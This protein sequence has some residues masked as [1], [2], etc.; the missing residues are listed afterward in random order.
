MVFASR[1]SNP[2]PKSLLRYTAQ[3]HIGNLWGSN[4]IC[5][6]C[7]E[8]L[9]WFRKGEEPGRIICPESIRSIL[10]F[11]P[12]SLS[13]RPK[14]C[15]ALVWKFCHLLPFRLSKQAGWSIA[16]LWSHLPSC[17][18][19]LPGKITAAAFF[20]TFPL[21]S[22][23]CSLHSR[24]TNQL[25]Q[26]ASHTHI[27]QGINQQLLDCFQ[28]PSRATASVLPSSLMCPFHYASWEFTAAMSTRQPNI[29]QLLQWQ[30]AKKASALA[31]TIPCPAWASHQPSFCMCKTCGRQVAFL[32][33][34]W[35]LLHLQSWDNNFSARSMVGSDHERAQSIPLIPSLWLHS[36]KHSIN[37]GHGT[38]CLSAFGGVYGNKIYHLKSW[39]GQELLH[40]ESSLLAE[41]QSS[42]AIILELLYITYEEP[43][44]A[45]G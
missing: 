33:V 31:F 11:F 17:S 44:G 3:S 37:D 26:A 27:S 29:I 1:G 9:H 36:R 5:L 41:S 2:F 40:K 18:L 21:S 8:N 14:S 7:Q 23:L 20:G 22:M 6:P 38:C 13:S 35:P 25:K 12:E 45:G 15:Q 4:P 39:A 16:S 32:S 34:L 42:K 43:R 30:L 28:G 19:R 10:S 24:E